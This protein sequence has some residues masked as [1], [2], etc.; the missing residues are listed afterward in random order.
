MMADH[1]Q[2][3]QRRFAFSGFRP[4][5]KSGRIRPESLAAFSR[6]QWPFWTGITG[7]IR[8]EYALA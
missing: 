5:P 1:R 4:Q 8:P 7:R 6:N 3:I 2:V